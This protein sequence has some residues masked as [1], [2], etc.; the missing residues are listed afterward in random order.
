M[1][2]IEMALSLIGAVIY[3]SEEHASGN[4]VWKKAERGYGFP[5]PNDIRG[6]L[7]GDDVKFF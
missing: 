3:A 5:V 4:L 7:R 6:M 2:V 1:H